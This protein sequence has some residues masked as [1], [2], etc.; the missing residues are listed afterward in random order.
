MAKSHNDQSKHRQTWINHKHA[1]TV[2][3]IYLETGTVV[4]CFFLLKILHD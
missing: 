3:N 1:S 4:T 2:G